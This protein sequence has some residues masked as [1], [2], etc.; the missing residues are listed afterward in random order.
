MGLYGIEA[1]TKR[2][3]AFS[4][5]FGLFALLSPLDWKDGQLRLRPPVVGAIGLEI[6]PATVAVLVV[7]IGSTSFDGFSFGPT[8][9][10]IHPHLDTAFRDLGLSLNAASMASGTLGLLVMYLFIGAVYRLGVLGMRTVGEGHTAG[11]LA[12]SFA[13]TLLPIAAAYVIAHYFSSLVFQGQATAY[14]ISDPLGD[15]SNLFGTAGSHIDYNAV[16]TNAIW[17]VQV[18]ALIVGHAAGL[19]LAHERALVIYRRTTEAVRSQYWMLVVMVGFTSLGLWIL[20]R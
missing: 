10:S 6:I 2:G 18:G 12:R 7:M 1:W 9:A 17:Y 19:T 5:Y 13:H 3:D 4:A 20:S 16:S 14:L 11:E 8:W 15:G